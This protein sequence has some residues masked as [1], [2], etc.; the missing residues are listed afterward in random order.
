MPRVHPA[1]DVVRH[2]REFVFKSREVF[3]SGRPAQGYIALDRDEDVITSLF[4]FDRGQGRGKALLDH[5]K[6]LSQ[7]LSLW[8]FVANRGAQRFYE[9]EGFEI[10][11]RSN[12]DNEENLP[13]LKY[14]WTAA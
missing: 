12:G 4:V 14:E 2:Y 13:D 5:A 9:R 11:G 7:R 3:V 6:A 1:D 8:T 10:V